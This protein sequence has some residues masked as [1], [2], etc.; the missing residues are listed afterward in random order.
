MWFAALSGYDG[1]PWFPAFLERLLQGS[2][3]VIRL[4]AGDPFPDHPPVYVRALLYDYRFSRPAERRATE[5][6]WT[7]RLEGAY[8]PV[9]S[10][11]PP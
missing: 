8:S 4:L 10:L 9:M 3:A 5:A 7:R 11:R 2:P 6:W 1:T